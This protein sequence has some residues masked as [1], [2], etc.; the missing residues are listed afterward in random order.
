[1][2]IKVTLLTLLLSVA[3]LKPDYS[4]AQPMDRSASEPDRSSWT[5]A[6][7]WEETQITFEQSLYGEIIDQA[8]NFATSQ[9]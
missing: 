6:Q 3:F 8:I 2:A 1:M 4:L 7:F 9:V 5:I